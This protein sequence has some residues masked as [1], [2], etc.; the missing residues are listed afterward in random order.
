MPR[1]KK[2]EEAP[3]SISNVTRLI[4]TEGK[5]SKFWQI[6]IE[7]SQTITQ[8]GKIGSDGATAV[9]QHADA[10]KAKVFAVKEV[11]GKQKKGY[12][13]EEADAVGKKADT[14][15][16]KEVV[17]EAPAAKEEEVV[18]KPGKKQK[19]VGKPAAK[20]EEPVAAEKEEVVENP[21][22]KQKRGGKSAAKEEESAPASSSSSATEATAGPATT[23]RLTFT[24]GKS[25]KFWQITTV[26]SKT[27]VNY[28]KIGSDGVST[29]KEHAN[30]DKAKNF[31]EKEVAGKKKKGYVESS[32]ETD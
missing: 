20:E 14:E 26:E 7:D 27:T 9:K 1:P 21:A 18:E 12:V 25:N 11:A 24:D 5:S 23:T 3:P 28:G 22:K 8:Y 15:E 6:T 30:A 32:T 16:V 10:E 19:R 29:V 13:I 4:C 31:A 17:I 2:A